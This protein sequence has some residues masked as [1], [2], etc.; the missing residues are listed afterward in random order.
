MKVTSR[1][2]VVEDSEVLLELINAAYDHERKWKVE[3]RTSLTELN[4]FIPNQTL[5]S[6]TGDYQVLLVMVAD[7]SEDLSSIPTIAIPSRIVGH[8]RYDTPIH[9]ILL[10][11]TSGALTNG[12]LNQSG[13]EG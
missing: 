5:D 7:E 2:A 12:K 11:S 10:F 1:R 6:E 3:N 4:K 9:H 13:S 8:I